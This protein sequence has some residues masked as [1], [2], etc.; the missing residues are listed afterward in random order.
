[1]ES[2]GTIVVVDRDIGA[3]VGFALSGAARIAP[4]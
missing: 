3:I 2:G 1:M 4:T